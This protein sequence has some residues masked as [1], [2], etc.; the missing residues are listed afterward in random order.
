VQQGRSPQPVYLTKLG[1]GVF[2]NPASWIIEAIR[3]AVRVVHKSG[4]S[5][6]VRIV[7]YGDVDSDYQVLKNWQQNEN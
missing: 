4:H 1:G 7:H 6:D 5:L 3:R 2:R